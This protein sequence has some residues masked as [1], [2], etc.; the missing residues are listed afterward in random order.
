VTPA[1]PASTRSRSVF[2][3]APRRSSLGGIAALLLAACANDGGDFGGERELGTS[4]QAISTTFSAT[5]SAASASYVRPSLAATQGN[6]A[7]ATW[8]DGAGPFRYL[9][10]PFTVA[11]TG[12]Y[13]LVVTAANLNSLDGATSD[14]VVFLYTPGFAPGTP[15]R[16]GLVAN[17]DQPAS[18]LSAI[19]AQTLNAGQIYYL[20][21]STYKIETSGTVNFSIDGP[22]AA[23]LSPAA[24]LD[25]GGLAS[26]SNACAVQNVTVTARTPAG[27]VATGFRGKIHFASS[28]PTATLPVDYTFVAADNGVKAFPVTLRR[29]GDQTVTVTDNSFNLYGEQSNLTVRP[30]T[31]GSVTLVSG[32]GQSTTPTAPFANPFVVRVTDGCGTGNL[33]AD[34]QVNFVAPAAGVSIGFGGG[35]NARAV[36]TDANGLATVVGFGG[37]KVGTATITASATVNANASV[38]F[39]ATTTV[40]A[41]TDIFRISGFSQT[42]QVQTNYLLPLVA[43]V[44]DAWGNPIPN[45]KIDFLLPNAGARA[46]LS[47]LSAT[48]GAD[49]NAQV[50]AIANGV[51]GTF[52]VEARSVATGTS[53]LFP[54]ENRAGAPSKVTLVSGDAQKAVVGE[55]FPTPLA[56]LVRDALNNPVTNLDVR[57]DAPAS[58]ATAVLAATTVRTD[59]DG[60]ALVTGTAGDVAGAYTLF[61]TAPGAQAPFGFSLENLVSAPSTLTYLADK[62]GTRTNVGTAYATPLRFQVKDG[63]GNPVPQTRIVLTAPTTG[64]SVL[65]ASS[66]LRTDATGIAQAAVTANGVAGAVHLTATADGVP[67]T[68]DVSL[69]NLAIAPTVTLTAPTTT[70]V[71]DEAFSLKGTVTVPG[72]S[73]PATGPLRLRRNDTI[74]QS[75]AL[76]NGV[77]TFPVAGL[78]AGTYVFDADYAGDDGHAAARSTKLSLVIRNPGEKPPVEQDA[79]ADAS[80]E[81]PASSSGGCAIGPQASGSSGSPLAPAALGLGLVAAAIVVRR[82]SRA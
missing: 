39:S 71:T 57:F 55:P 11:Q 22:G 35:A 54:M 82:R 1:V 36:A 48:T 7:A 16:N 59:G 60:K 52:T 43:G 49:G 46:T 9:V 63:K 15:T 31:P 76:A 12:S 65:L 42:A 29:V 64:P 21:L 18:V 2:D 81:A 68:A 75:I 23:T 69:E 72:T 70:P 10:Q 13:D 58:G 4:Q 8:I 73:L 34:A 78:A 3:R 56:V 24:S 28:D 37:T 53:A 77:V 20:V 79:G 51:S 62:N 6:Q 66:E 33:L 19:R 45:S 27:T 47:A 50:T 67:V 40:G 32:G 74:V 26:P 5:L 14:T 30:G 80:P 41:A 25:V 38:Q 44:R 17:D 61:A